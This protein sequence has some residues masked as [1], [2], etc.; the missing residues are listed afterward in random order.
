ML[1]ESLKITIEI[2]HIRYESY[3]KTQLEE[4]FFAVI[5]Q[6]NRI[7]SKAKAK[8]N[9]NDHT[10]IQHNPKYIAIYASI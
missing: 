9:A 3:W 4:F 10:Y 5:N 1:L 6:G 8:A 7:H 2:S